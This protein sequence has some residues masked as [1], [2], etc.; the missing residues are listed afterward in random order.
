MNCTKAISKL[1]ACVKKINSR[2]YLNEREIASIQHAIQLTLQP[3]SA[4][5]S[6]TEKRK[7]NYR[8][9]LQEFSDDDDSLVA[10]CAIA[11]GQTTIGDMKDDLRISLPSSIKEH[12]EELKCL[13]LATSAKNYRQIQG[14]V[15]SPIL[16]SNANM[17]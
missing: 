10:A 2:K 12:R 11:L 17:L 13:L 16:L 1:L 8:I 5:V 4:R 14:E 9:F 6:K 7:E 3:A 15:N